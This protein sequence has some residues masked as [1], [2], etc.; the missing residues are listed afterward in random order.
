M[1]HNNVKVFMLLLSRK[2]ERKRKREIANK[3][4]LDFAVKVQKKYQNLGHKVLMVTLE[5]DRRGLGISLAGHKDRNRMAVFV[6]GLNPKGAAHKNGGLHIGD[7]ILEV[8]PRSSSF[9]FLRSA[10]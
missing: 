5:K 8:R 10:I 1:I 3:R 4:L 9:F 7:E 6:C 2:R